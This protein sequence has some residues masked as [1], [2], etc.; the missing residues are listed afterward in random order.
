[1]QLA[2][3]II[4]C[5]S[6]AVLVGFGV[7]AFLATSRT[8][9]Q[10]AKDAFY[11]GEIQKL[12]NKMQSKNYMEYAQAKGIEMPEKALLEDVKNEYGPDGQA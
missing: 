8:G 5:L 2:T 10:D 6:L 3:L 12:L 9:T 1:M 11:M 4:G 7:G